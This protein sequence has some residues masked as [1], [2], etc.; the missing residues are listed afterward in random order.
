M[1]RGEGSGHAIEAFILDYH[2]DL[3]D[4]QIRLEFVHRL[5]EE[6]KYSDLGKMTRQMHK[7]VADARAVLAA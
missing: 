2:G 6:R 1:G 7:D 3:Y 5:R 4:R